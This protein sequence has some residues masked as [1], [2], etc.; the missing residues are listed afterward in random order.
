MHSWLHPNTNTCTV[1]IHTHT[2]MH[3]RAHAHAHTHT[4]IYMYIHMYI[5]MFVHMFAHMFVHMFTYLHVYTYTHAC[6]YIHNTYTWQ[7][8]IHIHKYTSI[9]IFYTHIEYAYHIY[10][11]IDIYSHLYTFC[12]YY[13]GSKGGWSWQDLAKSCGVPSRNCTQTLMFHDVPWFYMILPHFASIVPGSCRWKWRIRVFPA[14]IWECWFSTIRFLAK[15]PPGLNSMG[16]RHKG[17]SQTCNSGSPNNKK[18]ANEGKDQMVAIES[19]HS[20]QQSMASW[21]II[22]IVHQLLGAWYAQQ[23][24]WWVEIEIHWNRPKS[25]G[26]T[27]LHVLKVSDPIVPDGK[28][29]RPN[30][31][32]VVTINDQHAG[33]SSQQNRQSCHVFCTERPCKY[34]KNINKQL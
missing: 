9:H 30:F 18:T 34:Q 20:I 7:T 32:G 21:W 12:I 28:F 27:I 13:I 23:K 16:W 5:P 22:G 15:I 26:S 3:T 11:S 24:T 1:H 4:N 19:K 31:A 29:H 17:L 33:A 10:I 2:H 6:I 8:Y 25:L 14:D